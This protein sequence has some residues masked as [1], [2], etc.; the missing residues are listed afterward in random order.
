MK[1]TARS[2]KNIERFFSSTVPDEASATAPDNAFYTTLPEP[3]SAPAGPEIIYDEDFYFGMLDPYDFLGD[4]EVNVEEVKPPKYTM[5]T[6]ID[7][8]TKV[9]ANITRNKKVEKKVFYKL[10]RESSSSQLFS[11][12]Y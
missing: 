7:N 6:A 5:E 10:I 9:E 4:E 11:T 2:C 8:L 12:F 1:T 3:V